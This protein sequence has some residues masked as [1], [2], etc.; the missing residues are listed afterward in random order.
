MDV[1]NDFTGSPFELFALWYAEAERLKIEK[2][3]AFCLATVDQNGQ[4]KLRTVLHKGLVDNCISFYTN[5]QSDKGVELAANPK[6]S[7]LF[8]W[9]KDSMDHQVR[10]EG[11]V[12]KLSHQQSEAYYQSRPRGSQVGAW[13]SPQSQAIASRELLDAKVKAIEEQFAG[14]DKLPLPEFW[15]GYKLVPQ[16]FDFMILRQDR[17]HDRFRYEFNEATASWQRYRIAP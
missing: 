5:Y 6:A 14:L 13:A 16:R 1:L 2:P 11:R 3:E 9:Q 8:Y 10:I 15:G 4:P 7:A 17:L 12:E